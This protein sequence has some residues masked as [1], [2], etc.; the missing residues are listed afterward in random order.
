MLKAEGISKHFMG[1]RAVNRVSMEVVNQEILGVIGP[2]GAGKTTLFNLLT[3]LFPP[4]E[5]RILFNG[6]E[7]TR[8][9]PYARVGLGMAR[10]FQNLEI[11]RDMSVLENVMVGGHTR[12]RAGYWKSL[13]STRGKK[14]EEDILKKEA[15]DLLELLGLSPQARQPAVSLSYGNQRRVEIARALVSNPALLFLDEPVA[16]MNPTETGEIADLIL[17]LKSNLKL[18][19]VIIE[20]DMNLI[21]DIC[22]RIVVMTEGA[23]LTS[24]RPRDIHQDPRVLEAYLGGEIV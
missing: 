10:T 18:T 24:G 4:D 13:L 12:L 1:I 17:R 8:L 19:V 21:M 16:G 15:L 5:G 6:R 20:H 22:D 3:G 11:F 7:I 14:R 23:V 2:N 9:R